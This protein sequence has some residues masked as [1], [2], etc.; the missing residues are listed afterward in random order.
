MDTNHN[1]TLAKQIGDTL[2]YNATTLSLQ[3]S[4]RV[5]HVYGLVRSGGGFTST[6]WYVD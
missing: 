6:D 5:H 4:K 2:N 1:H 3:T